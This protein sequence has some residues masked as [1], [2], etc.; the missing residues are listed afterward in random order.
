MHRFYARSEELLGETLVLSPRE[1]RHAVHVLRMRV[2]DPLVVLTGA[3][4]EYLGEVGELRHEAVLVRVLRREKKERLSYWITL[5][6]AVPKGK[7]MDF[8]VQK[9]TELGLDRV[10]PLL[11]ERTVPDFGPQTAAMKRERWVGIGIEAM[12]QCGTTWLPEIEV[13][14]PL[15]VFLGKGERAELDLVA[16]LQPG[17]RHP[18]KCF[19]AFIAENGRLPRGVRVWIGP[20]GD[21]A[22]AELGRIAGGGAIPVTLGRHVLRSETAAVYA[23][24]VV[25]YEMGAWE[26]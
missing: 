16:S 12:K 17:A 4:E 11:T 22:P 10:V 8:I 20:E 26:R 19:D 9:A 23:M 5:V 3:G 21:F 25:Q 2:G 13:P 6:Q 1:S 7:T 24:S 14:I 18:R 15:D